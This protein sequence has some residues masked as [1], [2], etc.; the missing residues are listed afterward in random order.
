MKRTT[1]AALAT[2]TVLTGTGLVSTSSSAAPQSAH[3]PA[4]SFTLPAATSVPRCAPPSML[5]VRNGQPMV[6]SLPPAKPFTVG[7]LSGRTWRTPPVEDPSWR[8][9]FYSFRWATPYLQRAVNDGQNEAAGRIVNEILRF[10]EEYPDPNQNVPGWD[11][12]NSLRRL[13]TLTCVYQLTQDK[14]IAQVMQ[15]EANVLFGWRYYGPP[16]HPVH[17]HG[18][19]ANDR[20]VRAGALIGRQDWVDKA[21]ARMRSEAHLAFTDKGTSTEQSSEYQRT[22]AQMW[23]NAANTLASLSPKGENDPAV[24]DLR[25]TVKKAENVT[26]WVTEPDGNFVQ[27]GDSRNVKGAPAP[28]RK[29]PG[30][31]RDDQ[32]GLAVGRWSWGD[33]NTSYY[34]LRYGPARFAHGHLD[35]GAVTWST[36]GSRVLVGSGYYG[37]NWKDRYAFWARQP[38][39][40]NVAVPTG[41]L[42]NNTSMNVTSHTQRASRH[43]WTVRG[44]MYKRAYTRS[45]DVNS[46]GRALTV[47]DNFAGRGSADQYW[48][49]DPSWQVV[50]APRNSK[51]ATFRNEKGQTLTV[52]ST[53][54]L[55]LSKGRTN[56][57]SGWNFPS[58]NKRVQAWEIKVRWNSG[59]LRTSFTVK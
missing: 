28:T 12:G 57:V 1:V 36:A 13:E 48:H 38:Q 59:T 20:L 33:P 6:V 26:Q 32:A 11:E 4:S 55:G 21:S 44:N 56:P 2:V 7:S 8:L 29:D 35:K 10:Y 18:L 9:N 30:V 52:R 23:K 50:S 41:E 49:L 31:F 22:N 17:N 43:N 47:T 53:A 46:P 51:V 42:P 3:I 34:T 54:P 40:S 16:R 27:I 14:R 45:L 58:N 25:A 24:R 19:M 39:S 37:Y 5:P 15:R